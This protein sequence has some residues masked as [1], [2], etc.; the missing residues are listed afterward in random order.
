MLDEKKS[1]VPVNNEM[2]VASKYIKLEKMRFDKRLND[3]WNTENF[4]LHARMPVLMLQLLLEIAI[5]QSLE[6]T[7]GPV[8]IT[9]DSGLDDGLMHLDV[10]SPQLQ[11][12][13]KIENEEQEALGNIRDRLATH[14]E[15][16]AT[17]RL[18]TRNS[19]QC[20]SLAIPVYE[21]NE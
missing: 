11:P 21:G 12:V 20:L 16:R 10:C 5:R 3:V 4:P 1:L 8:E 18:Q 9:I 14:Y 6:K 15:N 13:E 2:T 19:T 7:S 17:L